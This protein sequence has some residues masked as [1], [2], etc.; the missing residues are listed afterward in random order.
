MLFV[1]I[2]KASWCKND[3]FAAGQHKKTNE[4]LLLNLVK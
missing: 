4:I 1:D 2:K 3:F